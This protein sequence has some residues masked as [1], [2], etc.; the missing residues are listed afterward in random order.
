MFYLLYFDEY[1]IVVALFIFAD[2]IKCL[3]TIFILYYITI[4]YYIILY[5]YLYDIVF[6]C[7]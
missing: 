5:L 3:S 4:I 1:F 2:F 6:C 7:S